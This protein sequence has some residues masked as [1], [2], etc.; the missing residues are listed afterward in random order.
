MKINPLLRLLVGGASA[1]LMV[2]RLSAADSL[3]QH[4]SL[5]A[6]WKFHLGD[7]WPNA[8]RLDKAGASGGPAAD[9]SFNDALWRTVDLPHDWAIE[10]PFDRTADGSHGFKAL[11]PGFSTNSIGWY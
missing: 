3:S 9:K 10:L 6:G 4:L 2:L 8:L 5:D 7:D 1:M 11:G